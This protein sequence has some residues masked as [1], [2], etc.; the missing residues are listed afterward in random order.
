M[1]DA[2]ADKL[3]AELEAQL[4][5]KQNNVP[6]QM[7]NEEA[8]RQ[9][10]ELEGQLRDKE[11]TPFFSKETA[12]TAGRRAAIVGKA[13][14]KALA[15]LPEMPLQ[16]AELARYPIQKGAHYLAPSAVSNPEF[17]SWLPG[18]GEKAGHAIDTLTEGYT[19]PRSKG[20]QTLEDVSEGVAGLIGGNKATAA[21]KLG[22]VAQSMYRMNPQ[23]VAATAGASGLGSHYRQS[24]ENPGAL[25]TLWATLAGAYLGTKGANLATKIASVPRT[26]AP[27][28][29]GSIKDAGDALKDVGSEVGGK[30]IG[31]LYGIKKE[32]LDRY[33][34]LGVQP[35]LGMAAEGNTP[36][37]AEI[38]LSKSPMM[39]GNILP[40]HYAEY[41]KQVMKPL[42][43]N[44]PE[45]IKSFIKNRP[46]GITKTGAQKFNAAKGS[47]YEKLME[48]AGPFQKKLLNKF[49]RAPAQNILDHIEEEYRAGIEHSGHEKTF[50]GKL[51]GEVYHDIQ[52][53]MKHLNLGRETQKI[54][55]SGVAQTPEQYAKAMK[56][57]QGTVSFRTLEDLRK[58]V[59][60]AVA[61]GTWGS[62]ELT[63]AQDLYDLLR[64]EK[65]ALIEA[66][67]NPALT[68]KL[69]EA[70]KEWA[71]YKNKDNGPFQFVKKIT[72]TKNDDEAFN[73]IFQR[74]A[75]PR[76]LKVIREGLNK[77]E[78][79]DFIHSFLVHAGEQE[80][81]LNINNIR[82]RLSK[83][84][85]K[86][87]EEFDGFFPTKKAANDFESMISLMSENQA[88]HQMLGNPS[89]TSYSTANIKNLEDVANIG[90]G[91]AIAAAAGK[92]TFGE[93]MLAAGALL[94]SMGM[95]RAYAKF[96]T[97]PAVLNRIHKGLSAPTPQAMK[98]QMHALTKIP[99]IDKLFHKISA[100]P[101]RMATLRK[102]IQDTGNGTED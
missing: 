94:L 92:A 100:S 55:D 26:A 33:K 17:G 24:Q 71:K 52:E 39:G 82:N 83:L 93:P 12:R 22:K 95:G 58:K 90:K 75:D 65:S 29:R 84:R 60:N 34:N 67:G 87:K 49:E 20:E 54:K 3:I 68:M 86:N 45:D 73:L 13:G 40:K 97:S 37:M 8:D 59:G 76:L 89:Q 96:S 101:A 62:E 64:G 44:N 43:V 98:Y 42:G 102:M 69:T 31:K 80:G 63:E 57:L 21:G 4:A 88:K 53:D 50:K 27:G 5:S 28:I 15:G 78:R 11:E 77:N 48:N 36:L 1:N 74:N 61:K 7:T 10:A 47:E 85:G 72:G 79:Q 35:T 66:K 70:R 81:T 51:A 23:T 38:M 56:D 6:R 99:G 41:Q 18:L 30:T 91:V 16:L 2:E 25:G 14:V 32:V 19:K 46:E 9:I